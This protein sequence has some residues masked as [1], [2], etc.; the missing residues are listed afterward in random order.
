MVYCFLITVMLVPVFGTS[1]SI[2]KVG[3]CSLFNWWQAWVWHSHWCMNIR[4]HAIWHA[5]GLWPMFMVQ[6]WASEVTCFGMT[7]RAFTL[8][9]PI[10]PLCIWMGW[11][12]W[13]SLSGWG[14]CL[15]QAQRVPGIRLL[16]IACMCPCFT[17]ELVLLNLWRWGLCLLSCRFF[18]SFCTTP[19]SK[20][21]WLSVLLEIKAQEQTG[22]EKLGG[23]CLE[24]RDWLLAPP[25]THWRPCAALACLVLQWDFLCLCQMTAI[26]FSSWRTCDITTKLALKTEIHLCKWKYCYGLCAEGGLS[27]QWQQI[28]WSWNNSTS[29]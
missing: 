17:P 4:E 26:L 13:S 21:H 25:L 6:A 8:K 24:A 18:G 22:R 2:S 9:L 27:P 19:Q 11:R 16:L 1:Q 14:S 28:G 10:L 29:A 20:N 12:T 5:V 23:L 7:L 3:D 15:S